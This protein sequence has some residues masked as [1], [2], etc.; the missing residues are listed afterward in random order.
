MLGVGHK[1][2]A[3]TFGQFLGYPVHGCVNE[4]RR[5]QLVSQRT[6]LNVIEDGLQKEHNEEQSVSQESTLGRM[7]STWGR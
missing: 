3:R 4:H 1:K 5:E 6:A 2:V 7:N